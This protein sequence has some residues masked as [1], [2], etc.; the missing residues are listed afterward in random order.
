MGEKEIIDEF[1]VII[2]EEERTTAYFTFSSQMRPTLHRLRLYGDKNGLE[3]D[4]DQETLI[5]LRGTRYTSYAEKFVP[6]VNFAKQYMGNLK[7][8]LGTF[9]ARDF[10][11]KSGMKYL[12]ESFYRS[13]AENTPP[14]IPYREILLVA[15]IMD[16]IF[17]QLNQQTEKQLVGMAL[18]D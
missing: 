17:A 12:L 7:T 18:K 6:P 9:L 4:H 1:R 3:M 10:H 14:P 11:M 5:K 13:I 8:N 15:R 16:N 2:T